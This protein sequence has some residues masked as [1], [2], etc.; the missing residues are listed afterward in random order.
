M[1]PNLLDG[2]D[3]RHGLSEQDDGLPLGWRP[4]VLEPS[5]YNNISGQSPGRVPLRKVGQPSIVSL[6]YGTVT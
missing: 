4:V 6:I 2:S 1:D 5:L 3:G